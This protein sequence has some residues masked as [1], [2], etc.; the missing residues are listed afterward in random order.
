[1]TTF[2]L[3]LSKAIEKAQKDAELIVKKTAIGLFSSV[4]EKSPVDTGRFRANWNL[5]FASPDES[6]SDNTDKTGAESKG[7]VYQAMNGYKLKDQSIYFTNSL[8]YAMRLEN[9]WSE[10]APYGMVR[11][12]VLETNKALA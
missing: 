2:A 9:G 12:S 8:P 5:S 7:R 4:I 1:V 6:T 11:L 10:Q 3:D